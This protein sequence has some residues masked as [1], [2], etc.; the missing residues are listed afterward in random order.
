MKQVAYFELTDIM[1]HYRMK[2]V[3]YFELT[4]IMCHCRNEGSCILRT[5]KYNAAQQK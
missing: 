4:D 1:Q 5:H 3:T 2:Q